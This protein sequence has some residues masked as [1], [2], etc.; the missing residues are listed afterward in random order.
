MG[1]GRTTIA[2]AAFLAAI[3]VA[4]CGGNGG[5]SSDSEALPGGHESVQVVED[6]VNTLAAGDVDAA[7]DYFALPSVAENGGTALTLHTHA[8]AVAFN[9]SLPCGAKLVRARPS[10]GA[11][12]ATFKLTERPGGDCGSGTGLLARTAFV[13]RDGKIVEW[14]RLPNP[15]PQGSDRGPLV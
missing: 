1:L 13:I 4:G 7:A 11:I 3:A 12:T 8:D 6:W 10:G 9:R 15:Q 14:R 2:A 5:S